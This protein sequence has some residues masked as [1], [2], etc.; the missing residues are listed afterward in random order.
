MDLNINTDKKI[1]E[2]EFVSLTPADLD[3][4]WNIFKE[5]GI[6]LPIHS[7]QARIKFDGAI[8]YWLKFI[9]QKK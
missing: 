1:T 8:I 7:M 9:S 6:D 4:L 3:T 2:T 5:M